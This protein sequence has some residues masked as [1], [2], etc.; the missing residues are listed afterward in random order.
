M[1][2][3]SVYPVEPM[4]KP[5]MTK[6]DA[7]IMRRLVNRQRLK[8]EW[9]KRGALLAKWLA[10]K[11]EVRLRRIEID[12]NCFYHLIFCIP[13]PRSAPGRAWQPHQ[14]TPDKDNLEKALLDAM[15]TQ[16]REVWDGRVS[17]VWAPVG[18]IIVI[19]FN[20][21][22]SQPILEGMLRE[23]MPWAETST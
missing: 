13:T 14:I 10:F 22:L 15:F 3:V 2:A 5:R 16:D 18:A 21:E 12:A 8:P 6:R 1:S 23:A 9:V 11:D 19:S 7:Y 20:V 17:K 4:A